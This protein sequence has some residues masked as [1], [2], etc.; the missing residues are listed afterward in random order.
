MAEPRKIERDDAMLVCEHRQLLE[1]VRPGA[2]EA[3]N[4]DQRWSLAELDRVHRL[5]VHE[6][7]PLL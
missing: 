4:E 5:A 3:M 1:P 2:R 7:P 6:H